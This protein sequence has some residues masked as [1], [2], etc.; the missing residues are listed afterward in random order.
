MLP[1]HTIDTLKNKKL[2]ELKAIAS[3]LGVVAE[4]KR[5]KQSW[6]DAIAAV[7]P[8]KSEPIKFDVDG[9][10]VVVDGVAIASIVPDEH[11]TQPWV[12][13]VGGAE[14]HRTATWAQAF[15]YVCW[16]YKQG[17]LPVPPEDDY[18]FHDDP[19]AN[20]PKVGD[21]HQ[22]G[23]FMLRCVSVSGESAVVWDV[24]YGNVRLGEISM[25]WN[26]LWNHHFAT[27]QEAIASLCAKELVAA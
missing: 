13:A 25:G 2:S 27:P 1:V 6:I 26:C 8:E 11:L 4:D 22:V 17:S 16:H 10:E 9:D 14:I 23:S 12:V 15:N 18:L 19:P 7:Q 20:L 5:S 21:T 24:L 3:T